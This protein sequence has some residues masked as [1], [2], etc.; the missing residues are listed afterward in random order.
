MQPISYKEQEEHN[1][2]FT[3]TGFWAGVIIAVI[4]AIYLIV[5]ALTGCAIK[6]SPIEKPSR[7]E[8]VQAMCY[9]NTEGDMILWM[10]VQMEMEEIV[11]ERQGEV[12]TSD[13]A[14]ILRKAEEIV[15]NKGD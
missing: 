2:E 3:T 15:A 11:A 9:G 7:L 14:E 1:R 13:V 8:L 10:A 6:A 4:V 5:V 12:E